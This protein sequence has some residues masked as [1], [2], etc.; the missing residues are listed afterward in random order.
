MPYD[1]LS[2]CL[3]G[4]MPALPGTWTTAWSLA[5]AL[6]LPLLAWLALA[7]WRAP[8]DRSTGTGAPA[9]GHRGIWMAGWCLLALALVSPLCRLAATLVAGHMAQL[10]VLS[11]AAPLLMAIG[12]LAMP[13][14]AYRPSPG[15]RLVPATLA[16]AAVLWMRHLP[17]VYD[18]ALT[19]P[20][21]HVAVVA[22]VV[23]ASLWFW[24]AVLQSARGG[25]GGTGRAVLALVATTAQTG[26]LGA[27]LTFAPGTFYPL[28]AGGATAWGLS[29]LEDQQLAGMLMWVPGSLAYLATGVVLALQRFHADDRAA[30]PPIAGSNRLWPTV[31]SATD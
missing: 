25:T 29:P 24:N 19:S 5:P 2:L 17:S 22:S 11:V 15:P 23:A 21:A 26:L 3:L 12:G 14:Q 13:R 10:L 20:A 18:A 16:Y 4:R 9:A 1:L 8:A 31:R 27:L 28:Q 7:L 30:P 6:V